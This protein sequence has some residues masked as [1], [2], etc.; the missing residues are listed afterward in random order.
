MEMCPCTLELWG[1]SKD[2][3]NPERCTEVT[4]ALPS[5]SQNAAKPP[6]IGL[7]ENGHS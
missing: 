6:T 2:R 7:R 3:H 4:D 1:V 5:P